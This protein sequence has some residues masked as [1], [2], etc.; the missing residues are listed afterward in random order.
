[1]QMRVVFRVSFFLAVCAPLHAQNANFGTVTVAPAVE[2]NGAGTNVDSIAFWEAPNPG[3]T[4]MFVT[5]KDNDRLEV[6]RYP[7]AASELAPLLF[8]ANIN[9]VAVDQKSDL[10]YVSDRIVS[11]FSTPGLQLQGTFGQGVVGVGENNL[12]ILNHAGGE[13]WIYVSDDHKVH[14]YNAATRQLL[15]SFAPPVSS[16]ETM[17]TDDFHQMILVAEEQGPAGN[18]GVYAF[19]PDGTPFPRNGTNRFGNNGEFDSD[20]EGMLLYTF[21][22]HGHSDD[23][24]GFVVVAD[25]RSDVTDFEFF[26]RQTW[27]HLGTF[28]LQGVSNTDGIASTQRE[29]PGYPL[30]VFAAIDNDTATAVIGWDAVFAAIGWDL[31]PEAVRITPATP[32]TVRTGSIE[33]TVAF[34]EP[35]TGFDDSADLVI[36]HNGTS[37]TGASIAGSGDR[38]TVSVSGISGAGSITLAVSTASDVRDLAAKTLTSSVSSAAVLVETPYQT[39]A[40]ARGLTAG[41]NDALADDPDNDGCANIREFATD[42]DPLSGGDDGRFRVA[43]DPLGGADYFTYTFAVRNGAVF[44]G[45]TVLSAAVDGIDYSLSGTRDLI[46]FDQSFAEV[47]PPLAANLPALRPGWTYRTFRITESVAGRSLCFVR[48]RTTAT[49]P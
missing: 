11:V 44:A 24:R 16:I 7:F 47:I 25:Q 31:P 22:A 33:F 40:S 36:G 37:S 9:G 35:V 23:G 21:P 32:G 6:W 43:V 29:L 45:E 48:L 18:P 3:D 2:L 46:N 26:D 28:R 5:G 4:L 34:S 42:G 14:R 49:P 20:E 13:T 39:W 15:G 41:I 38:F 10:L 17:L 8:P 19:H 1:M 27:S 12:A 30:G